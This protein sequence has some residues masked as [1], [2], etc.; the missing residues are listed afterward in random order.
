MLLRIVL[1]TAVLLNPRQI[2]LKRRARSRQWIADACCMYRCMLHILLHVASSMA[3]RVHA[4]CRHVS[5]PIASFALGC[6]MRLVHYSTSIQQGVCNFASAMQP[7]RIVRM[8]GLPLVSGCTFGYMATAV[9]APSPHPYSCTRRL[10]CPTHPYTHPHAQ[11]PA[12][13]SQSQSLHH[14]KPNP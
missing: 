11:P 4:Y 13:T 5:T 2:V 3:L 9:E 10:P 8:A 12:N 14:P 1:T 7:S 6:L